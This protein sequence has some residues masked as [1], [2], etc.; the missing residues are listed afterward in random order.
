[1]KITSYDG[2]LAALAP[3]DLPAFHVSILVGPDDARFAV[4][5]WMY[6]IMAY[7]LLGLI[8]LQIGSVVKHR[9]FDERPGSDVQLRML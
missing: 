2:M 9:Y 8:G 4:F 5:H 3:E 7:T 6:R 1:M